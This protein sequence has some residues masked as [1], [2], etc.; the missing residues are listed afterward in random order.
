MI[1]IILIYVDDLLTFMM[2]DEMKALRALLTEAFKS[3]T[4]EI[5]RELSYLG[6]Q[7]EWT[8]G[9]FE[10]SMDYYL[11]QLV[12]DWLNVLYRSGPGA[13]DHSR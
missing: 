11:E 2:K 1:F 9:A 3:I 6:M 8:V 10:I 4:M 7:I 5:G 12:K 13:K